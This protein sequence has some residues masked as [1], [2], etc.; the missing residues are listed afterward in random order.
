MITQELTTW[1]YTSREFRRRLTEEVERAAREERPYTV[2]ACVP[3]H[4]PGEGV[5]D[6]VRVAADCVH[7]LVRDDDLAGR[8]DDD[9]LAI[10][11][12]DTD[13]DGARVFCYRLQGDLRLRSYHLRNTV[14]DADFACLPE[15]GSPAEELL[16]AAIKA[17]KTRRRR[18]AG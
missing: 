1:L 8:L 17:A 18:L 9:I 5:G 6:I 2:V 7:N 11:L 3:Q 15:D 14:W 10:G 16:Q 13:A 4:L 12:P